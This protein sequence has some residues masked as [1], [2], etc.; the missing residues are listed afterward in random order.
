MDDKLLSRLRNVRRLD[1]VKSFRRQDDHKALLSLWQE[2]EY[3]SITWIIL[4]QTDLQRCAGPCLRQLQLRGSR[5][6]GLDLEVLTCAP[7][8]KLGLASVN[9]QDEQL[10]VVGRISSLRSLDLSHNPL[11]DES[12]D[13]LRALQALEFLSLAHVGMGLTDDGAQ[14][15]AVLP[16]LADLD[17]S[18]TKIRGWSLSLLSTLR[19]LDLSFCENLRALQLPRTV[20]TLTLRGRKTN[21]GLEGCADLEHL[22]ISQGKPLKTWEVEELAR[23]TPGLQSLRVDKARSQGD[24]RFRDDLC[25]LFPRTK[26]LV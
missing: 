25:R 13:H 17:L 4:D 3:L 23:R 15:L 9:L 19:Q 26:I 2:L 11:R 21:L 1:V 7:L 16:G 6:T 14:R 18:F 24:E 8:E 20:R 12:L 10:A 22:D 5:L